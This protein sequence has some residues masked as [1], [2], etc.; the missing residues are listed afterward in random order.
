MLVNYYYDALE[1]SEKNIYDIIQNALVNSDSECVFSS[2]GLAEDGVVRAW[3]AV[4]L[5]H[6]EIIQYPALFCFPTTVNDRVTVRFDYSSID[7]AAF[8]ARLDA[9]V[10]EIEQSLPLNASDYLVCKKIFDVIASKVEYD[11]EVERRFDEIERLRQEN[12]KDYET[13]RI[14]FMVQ[15]SE[16]FTPYGI[17]MNS[18]G[19]CQGIAKLYKILCDKFGIQCACVEATMK[20][21]NQYP[22]MLN[23]VEVS[24]KRAFVDATNGL[25]NR[26]NG[27]HMISYDF[28]LIPARIYDRTY[29]V[30]GN[31]GCTDETVNF[32]AKN[33]VWFESLNDMKSYLCAY[34]VASTNGEV[35][36]Y[37]NGTYANDSEL[38]KILSDILSE[39]CDS[40]YTLEGYYVANGFCMALVTKDKQN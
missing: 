8:Q 39:H 10:D 35:R 3:S 27:L 4:V 18:K 16:A 22:H 23:V 29:L 26:I 37:Y 12:S 40:A 34:T 36:C 32:Y 9:M 31:F 15:Y 24:G 7:H 14:E 13:R 1:S 21:E 33:G 25:I 6:P 2:S 19:V 20:G 30:E 17:V 28:F 38:S 11:R 5:E